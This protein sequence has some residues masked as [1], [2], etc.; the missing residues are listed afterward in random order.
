MKKVIIAASAVVIMGLS[1][2]ALASEPL[3][4]PVHSSAIK[5]LELSEANILPESTNITLLEQQNRAAAAN[6]EAEALANERKAKL[7]LVYSTQLATNKGELEQVVSLLL[8]RVGKTPYVFSGSTP[9]GWDC[10]GMTVWA[11]NHLGIELPHSAS[12]QAELGIEVATPQVGDLIVYGDAS[13]Y[14]HSAIYVGDGLLVHSGFKPGR[15]TEVIPMTHGSLAGL[16]YTVRRF[17]DTE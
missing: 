5:P 13:G 15:S 9:S 3:Q 6:A 7:D 14:F 2:A 17:L 4:E 16:D 8:D 10:S 1:G 12:K 11:Y